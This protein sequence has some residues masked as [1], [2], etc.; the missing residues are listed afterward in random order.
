MPDSKNTN[1]VNTANSHSSR[2]TIGF[3]TAN[4]YDTNSMSMWQ[5]IADA[6]KEYGAGVICFS[7]EELCSHI[8]F[9]DQAN[10]AYA[11]AS[12]ANVDGLILWGGALSNFVGKAEFIKFCERF[13]PLPLVNIAFLSKEIPS[14]LIDNYQCMYAML[15]HLIDV[16]GYRRIAFIRGPKDNQEANER[17]RAYHDALTHYQIPFSPDLVVIAEYWRRSWGRTA[18]ETLLAHHQPIE[19]VVAASDELAIGAIEVLQEYGQYVPYQIAVV[20]FDDIADSRYITPPLTTVPLQNYDQGRQ[21][22]E[23]VLRL[24]AGDSCPQQVILPAKVIIRQSCGCVEPMIAQVAAISSPL[25]CDANDG[26]RELTSR[27]MI[28]QTLAPILDLTVFHEEEPWPCRLFDTFLLD[29]N[30]A[31]PRTFLTTLDCLIREFMRIGGDINDWHRVLSEFRQL[32]LPL[33]SLPNIL[34]LAEEL[35]QQA[36]ILIGN[37]AQRA[38]QFQYAQQAEY[39]ENLRKIGASLI[40][41]FDVSRLM[42]IL[43]E[44]LPHLGIPGCYLA[45]YDG[46]FSYEY[47]QSP[48]EWARLLLAYN[49][50]RGRVIID[51]GGIGFRS[52]QL[53]PEGIFPQNKL[54]NLVL[55]PLYFQNHQIGFILFEIGPTDGHVYEAL[56]VQ[57]S[58]ALKG[59]ILLQQLQE[60]TAALIREQYV[61]DTFMANVPDAIYFKDLHSRFIKVNRSQIQHIGCQTLEEILGKTDFDFFPTSQ[62]Q[63]KYAQEQEIIQTGQPLMALEEPDGEGGWALTTKM[64]L[65]DERGEVIG[66][67]GISR[68]IT[69]LK[70]AEAEILALNEQLKDENIRMRAEMD[71][72]RR[73]QTSLLPPIIQQIH[74]DF[75]I[76]AVMLPAEEVGGDYYDITFDQD[77]K[78]WF[79]IGDVSGHGVTPGL[80]M[81]MA[82]TVHTAITSNYQASPR[83]VVIGVNKVLY[84]NVHD[85]LAADHFM[86][87]STLKYLGNGQFEHAGSHLDMIVYRQQKERCSVIDTPGVWL[88]FIPDISDAT[89]NEVF[90]LAIGDILILYTDGLIE[91]PN[92]HGKLLN[93]PGFIEIIIRHSK[94]DIQEMCDGILADV[95]TWCAHQRDDDMSLVVAR[96]IH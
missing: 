85:R 81:M 76:A 33:L 42:D 25:V 11:L 29:I 80:I 10:I 14:V 3:I 27:A 26:I 55:E 74:P 68:D 13:K 34:A 96:R 4:L 67:F 17:Y 75:E 21:A 28:I 94:K 2:R 73:I 36:R 69:A 59:D 23:M 78:L 39:V 6:A 24:I 15:A 16:H 56:R 20:G 52:Q 47:P 61:I 48:P 88:N 82:Q 18:M 19:V 71:L 49:N 46:S 22:V 83:D 72:A 32:M 84:K 41:T 79:G 7:G 64:P 45:V 93:L 90:H 30:G 8:G 65:R 89:T 38:I 1:L 77:G 31:I 63:L 12:S 51:T 62:A 5:G 57:I 86:T 58:S 53:L 37:T 54:A 9:W 60:Q 66:T 70:K 40:T 50:E 91:A 35:W 95:L 44:Q 87:F 43:A 92:N